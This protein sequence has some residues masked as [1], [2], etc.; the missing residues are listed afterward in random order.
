MSW[1][2]YGDRVVLKRHEA[3]TE[4]EGGIV[5]PNSSKEI[6]ARGDVV[7]SG[8]EGVSVG[9]IVH[10][11]RYAGIDIM[12]EGSQYVILEKSEVVIIEPKESGNG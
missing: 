1:K 3:K 10:F 9:D 5:I 12:L 2:V 7:Q 6:P 8:I 11:P 4:T